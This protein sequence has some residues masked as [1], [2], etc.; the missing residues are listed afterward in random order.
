MFERYAIVSQGDIRDA[1]TSLNV[2]MKKLPSKNPLRLRKISSGTIR[3]RLG[4][5]CPNM[6]HLNCVVMPLQSSL[7]D[8][9]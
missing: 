2:T 9:F 1:M 4:K 5:N 3:A 8:F 6:V 7:T